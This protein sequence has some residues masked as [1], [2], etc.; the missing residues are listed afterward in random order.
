MKTSKNLKVIIAFSQEAKSKNYA[1]YVV[2][3]LLR[4]IQYKHWH[5][6]EASCNVVEMEKTD[7]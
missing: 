6:I 5:N 2:W 1:M 4:S 3:W 7:K